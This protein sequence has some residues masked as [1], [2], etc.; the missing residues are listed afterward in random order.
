MK[1]GANDDGST[2]SLH[3]VSSEP[4]IYPPHVN[5]NYQLHNRHVVG[6]SFAQKNRY[7]E[8]KESSS[9]RLETCRP[10]GALYV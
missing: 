1:V 6:N 7:G 4:S 10:V 5:I 2:L 8:I 3:K 9:L